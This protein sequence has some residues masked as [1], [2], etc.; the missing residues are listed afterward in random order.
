MDL[1]IVDDK[2][3]VVLHDRAKVEASEHA[4]D[5]K[6]GSSQPND[7]GYVSAIPSTPYLRR[8]L[9]ADGRAESRSSG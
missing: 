9:D 5:D 7:S 3:L 4:S 1:E 8:S 6:A 2:L